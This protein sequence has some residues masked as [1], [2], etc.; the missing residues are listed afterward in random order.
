M[1]S[2]PEWSPSTVRAILWR[3]IYRGTVVWNKT[4]KRTVWGKVRQ[5]KR[6]ES[7]WLRAQADDLRIISDDLW[8][9]VRAR[10][11]ETESRALRF[12]G[13][14]MSGRPPQHA[15]KNL[16]AGLATCGLCGKGLVVETSPLK[17]GRVSEYLCSS[18]R[19]KGTCTNALHPTIESVNEACFRPSRNMRSRRRPSIKSFGSASETTCRIRSSVSRR[20]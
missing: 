3:E 2:R 11:K 5:K 9:R 17:R 6:P 15:I 8:Q 13:G 18:H 1:P 14:R 7:E 10:R 12:D 19:R 4:R 20:R 16:L